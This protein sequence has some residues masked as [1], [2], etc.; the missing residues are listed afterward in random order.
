[1]L[2]DNAVTGTITSE[3]SMKGN[4]LA[5][6]PYGKTIYSKADMIKNVSEMAITHT[7]TDSAEY[8]FVSFRMVYSA[9]IRDRNLIPVPFEFQPG[10][11]M[12]GVYHYPTVNED[13]EPCLTIGGVTCTAKSDGTLL[14]TGKNDGTTD[15]RTFTFATDVELSS[16]G[17]YVFSETSGVYYGQATVQSSDGGQSIW[18]SAGTMN[19]ETYYNTFNITTTRKVKVNVLLYNSAIGTDDLNIVIKPQ[20]EHN[21]RPTEFETVTYGSLVNPTITVKKDKIDDTPQTIVIPYIFNNKDELTIENKKVNIKLDGV[22]TDITNTEVGK[23]LL[24]LHT[25]Y[26]KTIIDC[27]TKCEVVYKADTKSYIDNKYAELRQAIIS[28]GG[29]L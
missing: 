20:L 21:T 3:Q 24:A 23:K 28:L 5:V 7:I 11:D 19:G 4:I 25:N 18:T 29:T 15:Y 27:H 9:G 17:T 12:N 13:G 10:I 22:D 6:C 8:P 16:P 1:M 26:P 2:A 14:I